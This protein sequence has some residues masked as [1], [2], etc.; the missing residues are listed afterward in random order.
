MR[1]TNRLISNN[2]IKNIQLNL[3]RVSRSQEQLATGKGMLRPSDRPENLSRLLSIKSS[4]S[5]LE[6]YDRNLDD[7]LSYL[8]LNDSSMQTLGDILHQAS[9]MAIEGA[10]GTYTGEDMAYLGEQVDKMIDQVKDLANSSVGDRYIYAGTRD[11]APPFQRVGDT[12]TYTGDLNGI[13]REVLSG[14][15]YRIDAPG[16]TSGWSVNTVSIT[17]TVKHGVVSRPTDLTKTGRFT[18][19]FPETF[20]DQ[21]RLDG[22][23]PAELIGGNPPALDVDYEKFTTPGITDGIRILT[24]DLAGLELDFTGAAEGDKYEIVIDNQLGVFGHG[25]ET[26]P[27]VFEVY[28]SAVPKDHEVDEGIFDVLF[29]LRDNLRSG[30]QAATDDSIGEIRQVTDKLLERR[31]GIGARTT[32]FEALKD[33]VTDS[34]IKLS[35]AESDL[36]DADMYKLS[37]SMGQDQV[38]FQASL[39][40][41]ANI[42][43]I[44]LLDFLK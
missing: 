23:T 42:I 17:T 1:V 9:Q 19:A 32:H 13:Y 34:Q 2:V 24:G 20:E 15:D 12:I 22:V 27:G 21:T 3:G 18:V 14:E 37:I 31:A 25:E 33:Q 43:Q 41:G 39:S 29:R 38:T 44:S 36:E 40:S 35:E 11:D 5:Y 30:N 26:A 4:I 7:G 8:N 28:N 6:Q 16:I 10:N